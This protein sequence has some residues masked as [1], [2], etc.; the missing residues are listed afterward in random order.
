MGRGALPA[1][2]V[3]ESEA[4]ATPGLAVSNEHRATPKAPRLGA[5]QILRQ[6]S[7]G[8]AG[9]APPNRSRRPTP[10][11]PARGQLGC[12]LRP[13]EPPWVGPSRGPCESLPQALEASVEGASLC[14]KAAFVLLLASLH[15]PFLLSGLQ[16]Q[17]LG[18]LEGDRQPHRGGGWKWSGVAEAG[19]S[20]PLSPA[21]RAQALSP[22]QE[23][24]PPPR[25]WVCSLQ[26][27]VL[28]EDQEG[29]WL[30]CAHPGRHRLELLS[31]PLTLLLHHGEAPLAQMTVAPSLTLGAL[32]SPGLPYF[33]CPSGGAQRKPSPGME[34]VKVPSDT[35]SCLPSLPSPPAISSWA[36]HIRAHC[37]WGVGGGWSPAHSALKAVTRLV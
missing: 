28:D 16:T 19:P 29:G 25:Q 15:T 20:L 27:S 9:E 22:P 36:D 3:A 23:L 8:S 33:P 12:I 30:G 32:Q 37:P 5:Y 34:F 13:T 4:V 10:P 21:L 24:P 26:S 17:V 35:A 18:V 2:K 6:G 1:A 11:F 31:W 14:S 7:R